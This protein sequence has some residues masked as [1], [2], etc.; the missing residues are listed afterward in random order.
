MNTPT[1]FERVTRWEQGGRGPG[2][3][4]PATRDGATRP[5]EWERLTRQPKPRRSWSE[6][7]AHPAPAVPP[8]R[9]TDLSFTNNPGYRARL[10]LGEGEVDM[11]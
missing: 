9:L 10:S 1:V 4:F 6:D 5:F 7:P 2:D 8:V 3:S 11:S